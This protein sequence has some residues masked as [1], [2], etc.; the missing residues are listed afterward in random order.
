MKLEDQVC[1]FEQAKK[2]KELG[3]KAD[4]FFTWLEAARHDEDGSKVVE[5]VP[6]L[7][8]EQNM[9]MFAVPGDYAY[10]QND[11]NEFNDTR[12]N[13]SAF[14]V[15]ELSEFIGKGTKAAE[16][17]WQ[18]LIDCVN[19]GLSGTV[20]YNAVA[21]AGFVITQIQIGNIELP[22]PPTVTE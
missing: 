5:W 19:S 9:D 21:L 13:Y 4:T 17:H 12:G 22:A 7:F 14:T 20:A 11:D 16:A 8:Y 15:S 3:I 6:V 10:L 1:S 18:W 2:L